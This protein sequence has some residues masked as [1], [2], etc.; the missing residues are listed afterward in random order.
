MMPDGLMQFLTIAGQPA[1]A[2]AGHDLSLGNRRVVEL[3]AV[4]PAQFPRGA[5]HGDREL[6]P[7]L[8]WASRNCHAI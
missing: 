2:A 4:S 1:E 7:Q 3:N 6:A 8:F 5:L